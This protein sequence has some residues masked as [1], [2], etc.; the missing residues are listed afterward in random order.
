MSLRRRLSAGAVVLL[1]AA[2]ASTAYSPGAARAT[3]P[4]PRVSVISDS[5]LTAVTWSNEPA[6]ALLENG[7]DLQI[8]AGVCRRLNGETCEFN[9]SHAPPPLRPL[10]P[11]SSPYPRTRACSD[12]SAFPSTG[13]FVPAPDPPH[14]G[15]GRRACRCGK[16]GSI[17]PPA[18]SSGERRRMRARSLCRS[19]SPTEAARR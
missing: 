17:S 7:L 9:G 1:A 5:I 13:T 12:A 10:G 3:A 6:Q 18:V 14:C 16:P 11:R 8:D 15:G 19:R 4:A 2:L